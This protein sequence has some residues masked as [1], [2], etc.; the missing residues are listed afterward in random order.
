VGL[1][2]EALPFLDILLLAGVFAEFRG[3]VGLEDPIVAYLRDLEA[4]EELVLF[5]LVSF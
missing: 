3:V 5:A 2:S 4:T 1:V